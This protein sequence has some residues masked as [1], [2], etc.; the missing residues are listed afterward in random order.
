M[1]VKGNTPAATARH[2]LGKLAAGLTLAVLLLPAGCGR[3]DN[4]VLEGTPPPESP[5]SDTENSY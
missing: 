3:E 1:N 4:P 5:P 2:R